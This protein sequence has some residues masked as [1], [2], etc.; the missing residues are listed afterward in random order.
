VLLD[1]VA[2]TIGVSGGATKV[3]DEILTAKFLHPVRPGDRIIIRWE[4]TGSTTR[5]ECRLAE[6]NRLVLSGMLRM[7]CPSR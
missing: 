2:R 3:L 1:E 6:P 5:F 7:R 4:T